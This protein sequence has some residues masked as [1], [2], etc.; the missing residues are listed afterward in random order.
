MPNPT[1]KPEV[2]GRYRQPKAPGGIGQDQ[3]LAIQKHEAVV[4]ARKPAAV[5][6]WFQARGWRAFPTQTENRDLVA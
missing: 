5:T 2:Q 4:G 3:A 6:H 1:Q